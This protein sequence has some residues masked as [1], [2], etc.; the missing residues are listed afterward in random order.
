MSA[1]LEEAKRG[2]QNPWTCHHV[3]AASEPDPLQ[4]Q[5]ALLSTKPTLQPNSCIFFQHFGYYTFLGPGL[6]VELSPGVMILLCWGMGEE[7][8]AHMW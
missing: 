8:S 5:P 4:E 6:T 2:R 7:G 1:V 3:G